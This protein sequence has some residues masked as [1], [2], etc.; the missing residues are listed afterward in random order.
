MGIP[1]GIAVGRFLPFPPKLSRNE[2]LVVSFW[3]K[4]RIF[5]QDSLPAPL[6]SVA[7]AA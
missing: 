7:A 3:I 5:I 4:S 2:S 1:G 6:G